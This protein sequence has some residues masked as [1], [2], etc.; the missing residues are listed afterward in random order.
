MKNSLLFSLLAGNLS[1]PTR[2]KFGFREKA[3]ILPEIA[4]SLRVPKMKS[5]RFPQDCEL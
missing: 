3:E 2:G 1:Y 5:K 4:C